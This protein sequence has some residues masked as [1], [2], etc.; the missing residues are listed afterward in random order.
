MLLNGVVTLRSI[1]FF[2]V[3]TSTLRLH[4]NTDHPPIAD[5]AS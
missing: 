3:V 5:L 4:P 1:L 2:F